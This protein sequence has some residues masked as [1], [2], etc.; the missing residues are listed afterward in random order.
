MRFSVAGG[1]AQVIVAVNTDWCRDM[2]VGGLSGVWKSARKGDCDC[3]GS[4][5][6][7]G[8]GLG[9]RKG[10]AGGFGGLCEF[11]KMGG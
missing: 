2:G 6:C 1:E 5:V 4:G 10:R 9:A 11:R 7:R 3:M 8:D